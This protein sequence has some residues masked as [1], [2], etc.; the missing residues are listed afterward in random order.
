MLNRLITSLKRIFNDLTLPPASIEDPLQRHRARLLNALLV[1][2][3]PLA[4]LL[5]MLEV[6]FDAQFPSLFGSRVFTVYLYAM[7]MLSAVYILSRAGYYRLSMWSVIMFGTLLIFYNAISALPPHAEINFII[8]IPMFASVMLPRRDTLAIVFLTILGMVIFATLPLDISRDIKTDNIAFVIVISGFIVFSSYYRDLLEKDRRAKLLQSEARLNL[9]LHQIPAIIWTTDQMLEVTAINGLMATDIT[10]DF[11]TKQ[12]IL[13]EMCQQALQGTT[14]TREG[15]YSG[16]PY[17]YIVQPLRGVNDIVEGCVGIAVDL[18]RQRQRADEQFEQERIRLL[19]EFVDNASHD[20]KT[21]L[22]VMQTTLYLYEKA[23]TE[24]K[25]H[26]QFVKIKHAVERLERILEAMLTMTRLDTVPLSHARPVLLSQVLMQTEQVMQLLATQ[27]GV[28]LVFSV[29][30]DMQRTQILAQDDE[31]IQ[32]LSNIIRNAI[33]ASQTG[34]TITVA[35]SVKPP[36]QIMITIRDNGTGIPEED[37][38]HIFERFY[39]V[40][41]HRPAEDLRV[42]MGLA[43]ARRIVERHNGNITVKSVVGQGSEFEVCLPVVHHLTN[44]EH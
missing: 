10:T 4:L 34:N 43:I 36:D 23:N 40:E 26:Q 7:L 39:R 18:T 1:V 16:T 17:Q 24:E 15:E 9:L 33:Q 20:L 25:R 6:A 21:P 22:T 3:A 2:F 37:L 30:D 11:V 38:L 35:A 13:M 42:G 19:R 29:T 8:I 32:A 5:V 41:K 31:V 12:T 44:S 27:H 28:D 14:L